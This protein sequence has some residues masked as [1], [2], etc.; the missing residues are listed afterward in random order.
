MAPSM[1]VMFPVVVGDHPAP[2]RVGA[3]VDSLLG[4]ELSVP[5]ALD[6]IGQRLALSRRDPVVRRQLEIFR[7]VAVVERSVVGRVRLEEVDV[8]N[9]GLVAVPPQKVRRLLLEEPRLPEFDRA[10]GRRTPD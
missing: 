7:L 4:L 9:E 2:A 1:W 8:E 5:H 6:A 3:E 10:D